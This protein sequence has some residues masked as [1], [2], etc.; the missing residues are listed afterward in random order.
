[1]SLAFHQVAGDD[2]SSPRYRAL[3]ELLAAGSLSRAQL[4][5]A[6]G[7]APST[8]TA[9]IRGLTEEGVV[10]ESG[11]LEEVLHSSKSDYT[12]RLVAAG[13]S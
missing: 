2:R 7:L 11:P 12:R 10:V 1:M 9:L 5:R 8:M 3:A 6:T 4:A 13:S